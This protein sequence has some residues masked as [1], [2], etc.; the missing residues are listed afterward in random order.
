MNFDTKMFPEIDLNKY[1]PKNALAL[2]KIV[3][4]EGLINTTKWCS[5]ETNPT[6]TQVEFFKKDA[7]DD[8]GSSSFTTPGVYLFFFPSPPIPLYSF[9]CRNSD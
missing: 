5:V 3:E 6:I 8:V 2:H 1:S 4:T 7:A 9:F